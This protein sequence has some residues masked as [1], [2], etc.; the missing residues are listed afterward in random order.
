MI[1]RRL[2]FVACAGLVALA[3]VLALPIPGRA[4]DQRQA[5]FE[6]VSA[7]RGLAIRAETAVELVSRD[8]FRAARQAS[9]DEPRA[10]AS[11]QTTQKL[12]LELGL[13][14]PGQDL[15]AIL[16]GRLGGAIVGVYSPAGKKLQ[17]VS[18]HGSLGPR[19]EIV[20]A[21]EFVHA[22]QDQHFDLAGLRRATAGNSDRLGALRALVEGDARIAE[23]EYTRRHLPDQL[24]TLQRATDCTGRPA[25]I[26]PAIRA[27]VFFPYCEGVAFV[28]VLWD[29]DGFGAVD[30]A[31]ADPPL[32]TE[33]VLHPEKYLRREAPIDVTLPDFATGLGPGWAL[34]RS[35]VLGELD[36]RILL[37][38]HLDPATAAAGADGWGG[39]RY[40]LLEHAN[41]AP[42]LA[43]RLLWDTPAEADQFLAAYTA[44]LRHRF[45]TPVPPVTG[46]ALSLEVPA[47]RAI[48]LAR[49]GSTVDILIT[50]DRPTDRPPPRRAPVGALG[51]AELA[52]RPCRL[53]V[54]MAE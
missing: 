42:A 12:M 4:E 7:V 44:T 8:D 52:A 1:A 3:L 17:V 18:E 35:D 6:R 39:G 38:E 32:S 36:V 22:L 53:P 51:A 13:L 19:E 43:I 29:A 23:L 25:G 28:R 2:T 11:V 45:N 31:Y 54:R 47:G 21:H 5:I 24:A 48:T 26:P 27:E 46:E 40:A 16:A 15:H 20:L 49:D 34:L 30:W 9:F 10:R 37:Q 50:T 14:Q 41:G 33:Q